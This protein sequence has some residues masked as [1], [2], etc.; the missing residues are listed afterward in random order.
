MANF[1]VGGPS[2]AV[3][4]GGSLASGLADPCCQHAGVPGPEVSYTAASQPC[5]KK[6]I[7]PVC[8]STGTAKSATHLLLLSGYQMSANDA[9]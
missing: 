1:I 3:S 9:C 2:I 4:V 5:T 6:N 7:M 8:G